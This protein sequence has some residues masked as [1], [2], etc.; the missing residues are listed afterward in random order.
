[1][2]AESGAAASGG[3]EVIVHPVAQELR[4]DA[5]GVGHQH[6]VLVTQEFRVVL[7]DQPN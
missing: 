7:P 1:M 4:I 6:D 2:G 5:S 3:S